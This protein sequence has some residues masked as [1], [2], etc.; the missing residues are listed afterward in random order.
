MKNKKIII[1]FAMGS[2]IEAITR[3]TCAMLMTT[4]LN[5][6]VFTN[7][8]RAQN[9]KSSP[10]SVA[11]GQNLSPSNSVAVGQTKS[12]SSS[13][14]IGQNLLANKIDGK[15]LLKGDLGYVYSFAGNWSK[16]KTSDGAMIG[17]NRSGATG[18]V[19]YGLSL[20]YTHKSGLGMSADYLGFDHKWAGGGGNGNGNGNAVYNYDASYHVV[21]LTP[22]YRVRFDQAN[23]WG[24]RF[25]LGLGFSISDVAWA[26][27]VAGN[28]AQQ[29]GAKLAGGAMYLLSNNGTSRGNIPPQI[30]TG[31]ENAVGFNDDNTPD[32][33]SNLKCINNLNDP[34]A[35][36]NINSDD[37]VA[38]WLHNHGVTSAQL[39]AVPKSDW[40]RVGDSQV[41]VY[42]MSDGFG[43]VAPKVIEGLQT[44]EAV[45]SCNNSG[46]TYA[47]AIC[48]INTS[49][50]AKD[51]IGF[52]IAP[53]AALEFDNG[54]LHADI[55]IKYLHEVLAVRYFGSEGSV[56][57][58][59][60][61]GAITYTS[62]PGPLA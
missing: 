28:G 17:D 31:C 62:K 58:Q 5:S 25:G 61:S 16:T 13:V 40:N 47:T 9:T 3:I 20:G 4:A 21:T 53:Q 51:D 32:P 30:G 42:K 59:K 23:H 37:D 29:N 22:N 45:A 12:P 18:G 15:L 6:L 8:A 36:S 10:N 56:S 27:Q 33:N 34:I 50:K 60:E 38:Q 26:Q 46:G 55:N 52:V 57:G 48:T 41:F 49:G 54:M 11:V 43:G 44:I 35:G 14:A 19:G 1:G 39:I 2:N 7:H 24:L